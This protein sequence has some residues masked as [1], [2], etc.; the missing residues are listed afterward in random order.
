MKNLSRA[1]LCAFCLTSSPLFAGSG[2]IVETPTASISDEPHP[3]SFEAEFQ[4]SY[5]GQGEVSRGRLP[6]LRDV[7]DIDED[8]VYARFVYTPR[9]AVGILRLGAVYERFGFN[10][11]NLFEVP[12]G[13]QSFSAVVGFDTKFSDSILVRLE[14][15]PGYYSSSHFNSNDFH[16]PVVLGG[17]YIYSSDLQFVLGISFDYEREYP[18]LVGGGIRWRLAGQWLLDAVMPTP[19]LNY[20]L[21]RDFTIF[22]GAD[23]KNSSFRVAENFGNQVG[24]P[25]LNHAVLTYNELRAA[26]GFEWKIAPE[27]KMSVEGGYLAWRDFDY[28]RANIRYHYEQ[29][30]PYGSL[31]IRAAF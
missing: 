14:A 19:R 15:T 2:P 17:T 12:S 8:Y 1:L 11:P 25:R 31:S 5:I 16:V 13:L 18:V 27:I 26:A 28:Y 29:G 30:A 9:I 20:E 22:V 23:M 6:N 21:T 7:Q 3:F 24:D 4:Y 10:A